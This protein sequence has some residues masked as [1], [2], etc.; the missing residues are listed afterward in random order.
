MQK[1]FRWLSVALLSL[2]AFWIPTEAQVTLTPQSGPNFSLTNSVYP[3]YRYQLATI[4][5]NGTGTVNIGSVST[6]TCRVTGTYTVASTAI[7]LSNDN[8][9]FTTIAWLP[10][11]GGP[12]VTSITANGLYQANAGGGITQMRF[13]NTGTF[14]GTSQ[15]FNCSGSATQAM[16]IASFDT[17]PGDPC[18]DKTIKKLSVPVGI[19]TA[20]T[21]Q[22]VAL[23]A[24]QTIFP[25][26][27]SVVIGASTTVVLEYGTG[28][29][30]GTGTTTLSG[31]VPASTYYVGFGGT[32]VNVP[33]ANAVCILSTGT[34]GINGTFT[35]VQE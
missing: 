31:V 13:N 10:V 19:S 6:I 28:S 22:L 8:T 29:N 4:T 32:F 21:T 23:V 34:G 2:V 30:C 3:T 15:I 18:Q 27:I 5:G 12:S 26:E 35:Y 14:T 24:G 20:T 11:G 25:C 16:D 17:L 7:Q 9:N 1:M 33:V